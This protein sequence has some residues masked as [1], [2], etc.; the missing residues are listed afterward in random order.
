MAG[1]FQTAVGRPIIKR[2]CN[3]VLQGGVQGE[4]VRKL[5]ELRNGQGG[6][7]S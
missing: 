3:R 4:A 2:R 6:Q 5:G 7:G 1:L